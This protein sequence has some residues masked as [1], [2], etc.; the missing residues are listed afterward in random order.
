LPAKA[1][2]RSFRS[3]LSA[4]FG[5]WFWRSEPPAGRSPAPAAIDRFFRTAYWRCDILRAVQ[6]PDPFPPPEA[7]E[8]YFEPDEDAFVRPATGFWALGSRLTWISALVLTI[9]PFTGW[10]AGPDTTGPTLAVIGWHT[11][12]L[13]K[14]VFFIGLT[15]LALVILSE[16]GFE[17]PPTIPESLVV[18][19]LGSLATIFVLIRLI[20]IPDSIPPPAGRGIG[21]W[22]SLLAS[23]GVIVAGLLRASE[24]L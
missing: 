11:G 22:I 23:L 24:E 9:A 2:F 13:G 19:A 21:I 12:V 3:R 14:L 4:L 7:D 1:R 18:I 15:L 10:Y 8:P 16:F 5:N 17:L 6:T 20:S